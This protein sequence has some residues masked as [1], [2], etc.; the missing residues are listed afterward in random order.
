MSTRSL[1]AADPQLKVNKYETMGYRGY[2]YS[3]EEGYNGILKQ[4]ELRQR[5]RN[6]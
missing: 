6:N 4:E 1:L 3:E 2:A 5:P